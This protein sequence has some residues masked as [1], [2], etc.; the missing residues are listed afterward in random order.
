[1]FEALYA[2]ATDFFLPIIKVGVQDFAVTAD[3]TPA[4]GDVKVSIDGGAD[5]NITTLPTVVGVKWKFPLSAAELT[6][7]RIAVSVVD[8]ATKAVE[9]Q[10]FVVE[11]YGHRLAAHPNIGLNT[12]IYGT[13]ATAGGLT[14]DSFGSSLTGLSASQ[15][16]RRILKFLSG[17]CK[18]EQV[19]ITAYAVTNGVIKVAPSLTTAPANGDEFVIL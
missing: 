19:I 13:A 6:G 7:K 1:M 16:N 4:A 8:A 18:G 15:L 3:W 9:D 11:T 5:A 12:P 14:I 2:T 17:N 10:M